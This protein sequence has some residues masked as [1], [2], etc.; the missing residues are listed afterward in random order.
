MSNLIIRLH[1]IITYIVD[2]WLPIFSVKKI[3]VVCI[4]LLGDTLHLPISASLSQSD[5]QLRIR[6]AGRVFCLLQT[7]S[8]SSGFENI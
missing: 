8:E 5:E 1:P 2:G 3:K 4:V 7:G 6:A